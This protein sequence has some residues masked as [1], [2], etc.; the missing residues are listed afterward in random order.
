M[1]LFLILA[2]AAWKGSVDALRTRSSLILAGIMQITRFRGKL[3]VVVQSDEN[4]VGVFMLNSSPSSRGQYYY[5]HDRAICDIIIHRT[6][7]I[8][9]NC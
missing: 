8:N 7:H 5:S 1:I 9:C 6:R 2:P 3:N 4:D